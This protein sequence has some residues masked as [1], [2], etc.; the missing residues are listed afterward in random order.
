MEPTTTEYFKSITE[1]FKGFAA[2]YEKRLATQADEVAK[3]AKTDEERKGVMDAMKTEL[4]SLKALRDDVEQYSKQM[5]V[6]SSDDRFK[7]DTSYKGFWQNA[8]MA[9]DMGHLVLAEICN[10]ESSA[11]HL[12][13]AGYK[14]Y[15]D[16]GA[17]VAGTEYVKAMSIGTGSAGGVLTPDLL[18]AQLIRKVEM[19]GVF[20]KHAFVVPMSQSKQTWPKRTGGPTVYYPDEGVALTASDIALTNVTVDASRWGVL[21]IFSR[22]LEEDAVVGLGELIAQEIALALAKAEDTNGFMGDGTGAFAGVTGIFESGNVAVV[23]M[24]TGD[25]SMDDI[26][27]DDTI[28]LI[29]ATPDYVR[30]GGQAK[31]FASSDVTGKLEKIRDA[32]GRPLYK[33]ANEGGKL[34][35]HGYEVEEVNVLPGT[36]ED[37]VSTKFLAFGSIRD[38]GILGQR[39]GMRLERSN[40][41][42]FLED[43]IAIK[44]VP[45]QTIKESDGNAM[46]VLRTAAA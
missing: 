38:W 19:Y 14:F 7:G 35:V 1:K 17:E 42:K 12:V 28:D 11:K 16:K 10:R 4:D 31:F 40:E 5:Q 34:L 24:G 41:L 13:E 9:A 26:A 39:R 45:R 20:R 8:K 2:D 46:A 44:A 18:I 21:V 43:Q 32:D 30:M 23:T 6:Q 29:R 36:A 22:E 33:R 37:A 3:L 27:D 25:T 15:D